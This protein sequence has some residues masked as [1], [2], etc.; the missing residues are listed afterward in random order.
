MLEPKAGQIQCSPEYH[1]NAAPWDA[2]DQSATA[3]SANHPT[4]LPSISVPNPTL[5]P[6]TT[7]SPTPQSLHPGSQPRAAPILLPPQTPCTRLT[8]L[9]RK[10][11]PTTRP[12]R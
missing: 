8:A 7:L 2:D 1:K 6:A 12:I 9:G 10:S 3:A 4:F 11:P 5:P